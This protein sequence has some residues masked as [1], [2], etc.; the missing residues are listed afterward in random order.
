MFNRISFRN[1]IFIPCPVRNKGELIGRQMAVGV[2][3]NHIKIMFILI[4]N[5][6]TVFIRKKAPE[7]I[8]V[9]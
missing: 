9:D 1:R 6:R 4:R 2:D 8:I 3:I 7:L 5:Y